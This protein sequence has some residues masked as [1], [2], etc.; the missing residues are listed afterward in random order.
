MLE[1]E[2]PQQKAAAE[3]DLAALQ[4]SLADLER[5][6][7]GQLRALRVLVEILVE[8]GI[9]RHDEYLARIRGSDPR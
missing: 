9:L 2:R 3:V 4:A 5:L 8:K 6:A 1:Q 7:G